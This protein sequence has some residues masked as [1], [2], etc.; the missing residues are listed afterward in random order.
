MAVT[1]DK[2]ALNDLWDGDT[3]QTW[4]YDT[5][6]RA[7]SLFTD[8]QREG[9]A[10]LGFQCS[11]E[12]IRQYLTFTS[13]D[14]SSNRNKIYMWMYSTGFLDTQANGG[15]QIGVGDGTNRRYYYVGGSDFF[16]HQVGA[17]S[18][19][20]LD[21]QNL[22]TNYYQAAGSAAP[23]FSAI[24]QVGCGNK[25]LA[26][27]LGGNENFFL[28]IARWGPGI[29]VEGGGASTQGTWAEIAAD[30][31]SQ[32]ADKA[33]GIVREL[34]VGV[35]GIQGDV[36]FGD[37]GTGDSYFYDTDSIIVVEDTGADVVNIEVSGNSTGTNSFVNGIKVGTGD[38]AKGRNGCTYLSAG[39][40]FA[41]DLDDSNMDEVEVYGSKF[42]K[43]DTFTLPTDTTAEFIGN[44]VDQCAMV[45]VNQCIVRGCIFSVTTPAAA[46][47][48]A[49]V[50]Y[51]STWNVRNCEFL[52]NNDPNATYV[53][54]GIK[55]TAA[56][57]PTYY[58]LVF[59]TN[60]KDVWFSAA[61][62][63]LTIGNN[64]TS[65]TSTYTNDSSGSVTINTSVTLKVLV[66]DRDKVPIQN[67][68]TS[69]FLENSPY[70]ELMNEDTTALGIA[71]EAYNYPGSE[72]PVVVKVRKSA[73]TDDPR[74]QPFSDTQPIT[75][76][77]LTLTVTLDEVTVPI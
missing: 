18:C 74:Y 37:N 20:V 70:T 16:G 71:E 28:D 25:T 54:H 56:A 1:I 53:G 61:T 26:K 46:A 9:S 29:R 11:N 14:M 8:R 34:A 48:S 69:I 27:S 41:I 5:G 2:T 60:E 3:T 7:D 55:H 42:Q 24:T 63:D 23:D 22:P 75:A 67:A 6:P 45:T 30:D 13:F 73:T 47:H 36:I 44:S 65:N 21:P 52:A 50:L 64:G 49:A 72:V 10:C 39:P 77:G 40:T 59:T 17:W 68:Q 51:N 58:D 19:F 76:N 31:A 15:F 43:V 33:Y 62:G 38:T 12:A 4:S 57:T 32:T 35:Y 66:Q